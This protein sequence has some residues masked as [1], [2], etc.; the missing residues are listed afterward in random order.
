MVLSRICHYTS[1]L[2]SYLR[3]D[4]LFSFIEDVPYYVEQKPKTDY[5]SIGGRRVKSRQ[6]ILNFKRCSN[7]NLGLSLLLSSRLCNRKS[8]IVCQS[9]NIHYV[10][11]KTNIITTY[12]SRE[13]HIVAHNNHIYRKNAEFGHTCQHSVRQPVTPDRL[14]SLPFPSSHKACFAD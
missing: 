14:F 10:L 7:D 6:Y 9:M 3:S 12:T 1:I 5:G 8:L 11:P 13:C 2:I 4:G